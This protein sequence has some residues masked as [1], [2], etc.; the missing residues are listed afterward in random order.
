MRKKH[1]FTGNERSVEIQ[2]VP[3]KHA[4]TRKGNK[5][6]EHRGKPLTREIAAKILREWAETEE[7]RDLHISVWVE[8]VKNHH[9]SH[10]GLPAK[11]E[12]EPILRAALFSLYQFGRA[13]RGYGQRWTILTARKEDVQKNSTDQSTGTPNTGYKYYGKTFTREIAS[14]IIV[15]IYIGKSPVDLKTIQE[16]VFE[17]HKKGGGLPPEDENHLSWIIRRALSHLRT[18]RCATQMDSSTDSSWRIHE[19]DVHYD[20]RTYPKTL[21]TGSETVYLY[22]Y[23]I[24]KREAKS[25]KQRFWNCKIGHTTRD[26]IHRVKEQVKTGLPEHAIIALTIKTDEAIELEKKMQGILRVLG[27]HIAD[28]PGTEWFLTSPSQVESIYEFICLHST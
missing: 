21:G 28:A 5:P 16:T 6:Y 14:E 17:H 1:T 22:Y 24:Y 3:L 27:K 8:N 13:E 2:S 15:E 9:I 4:Y 25:Q 19:E 20:E 10:G 7:I 12:L 11:G 18:R 23:P 26:S